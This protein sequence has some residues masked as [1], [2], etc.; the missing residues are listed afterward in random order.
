MSE[1]KEIREIVNQGGYNG[2]FKIIHSTRTNQYTIVIEGIVKE[3]NCIFDNERF[4]YM[5]NGINKYL[6]SRDETEK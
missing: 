4:R 3:W 5:I 2:R 1:E 6:A